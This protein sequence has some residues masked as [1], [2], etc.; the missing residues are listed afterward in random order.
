MLLSPTA[1]PYPALSIPLFL[2]ELKDVTNWRQLGLYLRVPNSKLDEIETRFL[3]SQGF[4]R[5]KEAVVGAWL[6]ETPSEVPSA[7]WKELAD[8][9]RQIGEEKLATQLEEKYCQLSSQNGSHACTI[10]IAV[11]IYCISSCRGRGSED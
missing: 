3:Q 1:R 5:C 4:D 8:V 10:S 2:A 9:L 7:S 6:Q 11:L